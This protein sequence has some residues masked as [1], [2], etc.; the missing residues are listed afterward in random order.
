M[1]GR[2][3]AEQSAQREWA[4]LLALYLFLGSLGGC[5]FLLA[6]LFDLPRPFLLVSIGLVLLG[7]ITLLFKLGS[8]QRA[9]RAISRPTTSWISRGVWF[10]TGFFVFGSLS[11]A[12]S[13]AALPWFPW[14]DSGAIG[15]ALGWI[16]IA[17]ALLTTLYP[18]FVLSNSRAIPFWNT[19]IL[20]LLFFAYAALAASGVVLIG[21]SS[22]PE[23]V[24]GVAPWVEGLIGVN[25]ALSAIY[26]IAMRSAGGSAAESVRRLMQGQLGVIYWGGVVLIGLVFPLAALRFTAAAAVLAGACIQIGALLFRYCVL[27]A[28]VYYAPAALTPAKAN[29]STL[30]R[31]SADFAREYAGMAANSARGRR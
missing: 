12:S 8:P 26:L 10:V 9:W 11:V 24:A 17:F 20:P 5:L 13:F 18:G 30:T 1:I 3:T 15:I 25:A 7:A 16:A 31:T 6:R 4:W 19:P 23:S 27:R 29:F 28:G 2:F 14:N 22:A 21:S